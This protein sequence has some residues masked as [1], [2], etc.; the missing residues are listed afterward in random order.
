MFSSPSRGCLCLIDGQAHA[1]L[2]WMANIIKLGGCLEYRAIPPLL[3]HVFCVF[4]FVVLKVGV[5][6]DI[7]MGSAVLSTREGAAI[8]RSQ[9]LEQELHHQDSKVPF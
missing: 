2:C 4:A 5:L 9:S 1:A 8:A 3:W 7:E 6:R